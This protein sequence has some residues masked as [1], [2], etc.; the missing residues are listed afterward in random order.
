MS[1][2]FSKRGSKHLNALN[3]FTNKQILEFCTNDYWIKKG[4]KNVFS[5][6]DEMNA[7]QPLKVL[8]LKAR[9]RLATQIKN[10]TKN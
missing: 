9:E 7:L 5:R 1:S 6:I 3:M 2:N 8:L 10:E 4:T